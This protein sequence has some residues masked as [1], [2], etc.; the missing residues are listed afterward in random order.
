MGS[1]ALLMA[2]TGMFNPLYRVGADAMLA[3]L[4]PMEKRIDAYSLLRMSNNLGVSLGPAVGG[5]LASAS[6][7]IAFLCAMAG[8]VGYGVMVLVFA[9]ETI[10][11]RL[12]GTKPP[13]RELVR[14]YG[15]VFKDRP[16]ITFVIA[17]TLI[18]ISASLIWVLLGVYAKD[19]YGILEKQYGL[20]PTTNAVMVVLFQVYVTMITKRF[21]PLFAL[22]AG[23]FLYASGVGSVA[24]GRGFWGFWISIVI[25]TLG[26]LV[27]VPTSSTYAAN[28][29]P[30]D[31][32]GRY[33]SIY[34]LTWTLATG[35]GPV[36]G[37]LLNDRI[38]PQAIWYGG[39]LIGMVS[40]ASFLLL[41][42]RYSRERTA[43]PAGE[44]E[45]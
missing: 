7:E 8:L 10:P 25:V 33:L 24:L 35:V 19:N 12:E 45:M 2:L 15:R 44:K 22:A 16:Y 26:E 32:R 34:G 29:A 30:P 20:I 14:G 1:F 38:G 13:A 41:N 36:M 37:G 9:R 6:Y 42:R 3:D 28:S 27:L 43:L 17:F 21:S 11:A 4:I 23:A 5:V 31:M 39:F 18:Q 40:T